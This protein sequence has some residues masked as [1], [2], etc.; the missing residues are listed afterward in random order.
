MDPED[1]RT[2]LSK[3]AG[4]YYQRVQTSIAHCI[5]CEPWEDGECAWIPGASADLDELS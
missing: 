3:T 4:R 1:F 5:Y 2:E